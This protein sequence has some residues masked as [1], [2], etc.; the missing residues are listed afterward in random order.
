MATSIPEPEDIC[1]NCGKA[2]GGDVKLKKCNGCLL[3]KYCGIDCQKAHR[4]VHKV[5]CKKR[6]AELHEEKLFAEPPGRE[7]CPVCFLRM[8]FEQE[9]ISYKACCGKEICSGCS[10][11]D[12]STR[13][14]DAVDRSIEKDRAQVFQNRRAPKAKSGAKAKGKKGKAQNISPSASAPFANLD[15]KEMLEQPCPFCRTPFAI[16]VQDQYKELQKRVDAGDPRAMYHLGIKLTGP[17]GSVP[18]DTKKA[19]ELLLRS[20]QSGYPLANLS[21]GMFY[22]DGKYPAVFPKDLKKARQY[23]EIGAMG[24]D[25]IARAYLGEMEMDRFNCR[26]GSKHYM[27]SASCGYEL[28]LDNVLNGYKTGYVSKDEY[29]NTL[30]AYKVASD[31][32][33]S[34]QRTEADKSGSGCDDPHNNPHFFS[35]L[36]LLDQMRNLG[37]CN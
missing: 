7:E 22:Y 13:I 3:V 15:L 16:K 36:D 24:G 20:A 6:A 21:V 33:K 1:A 31:E 32:M 25:P 4:P 14:T 26:V 9:K 23:F 12:M 30:R 8:P 5:A 27:I 29:A 35:A 18:A 2:G 11:G 34:E 17:M 19:R 37:R 28:A 10:N